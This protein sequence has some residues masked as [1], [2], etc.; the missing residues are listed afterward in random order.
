MRHLKKI[1]FVFIFIPAFFGCQSR[2]IPEDSAFEEAKKEKENERDTIV[3][4]MTDTSQVTVVKNT[5]QVVEWSQFVA[6]MRAKVAENERTIRELKS[7][8][9]GNK[10]RYAQNIAMLENDNADLKRKVDEFSSNQKKFQE[11]MNR[12]LGKIEDKIRDLSK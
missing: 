1:A 11:Q 6:H 7:K 12:D 10:F 8:K 5:V 4:I 3:K 9:A 2:E